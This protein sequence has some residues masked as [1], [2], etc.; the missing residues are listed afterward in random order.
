MS[1]PAII[2][3]QNQIGAIRQQLLGLTAQ[4]AAGQKPAP[5]VIGERDIVLFPANLSLPSN[6]DG[7]GTVF[8]WASSS[9]VVKIS[10]VDDSAS[11]AFSR[12]DGPDINSTLSGNVVTIT[13]LSADSGYVDI[14]ATKAGASVTRRLGVVKAK[15][16]L[17]GSS[18][19][20]LQL[21]YSIDGSTIWHSTPVLADQ[22]I[23]S[24]TDG[25]S[26]YGPSLK[27]VGPQGPAG[28]QG[29]QGTPG[30][31]G[32]DGLPSY[33][34]VA[35]ATAANGSAGF[36][37]TSGPYIGTYTDS[38]ATDSSDYTRYTWRQFV[39]SQ[40]PAGTDG[41]DGG[42]GPNGLTAYLH[43]KY[44]NDG[45]ATFTASSGETPGD[46]LG[47][48]TDNTLADSS[49]VGAYT[50]S[51]IVGPSGTPVTVEYSINGSTLWHPTFVTGDIYMRQNGGAAIKIVGEN[52]T[53]GTNGQYTD[54]RFQKNT[55]ATVAPS[56]TASADNPGASWLDAPATLSAGE[57]NWMI[58]ADWRDATRL[59][60]WSAPVR[61]TGDTGTS[62]IF[63]DSTAIAFLLPLTDM[64]VLPDGANVYLQDV[65]ANTSGWET[66]GG[67]GL[68]VSGGSLFVPGVKNGIYNNSFQSIPSKLVIIRVRATSTSGTIQFD[69]DAGSGWVNSVQ[70]Q[71]ITPVWSHFIRLFPTGTVSWRTQC[72][73]DHEIDYI[74]IGDG[75]Y[76][77]TT[78]VLDVSQN[79][80]QLTPQ[81]G[82]VRVDGPHGD[83]V[84]T[85]Y[86]YLSTDS[87]VSNI[88]SIS[89]RLKLETTNTNS[90]SVHGIN[91]AGGYG[92]IGFGEQTGDLGDESLQ[93]AIS[94]ALVF[95]VR[96]GTSYFFDGLWHHY[97]ITIDGT[98]NAVY[99]D[100]VRQS[101]YFGAGST[102]TD[103]TFSS[104]VNFGRYEGYP[105]N[106]KT[107]GAIADIRI[108]SRALSA[109]EVLGLYTQAP[110]PTVTDIANI[111]AKR[112]PGYLGSGS[113]LPVAQDTNDWALLTGANSV[114]PG[115]SAVD[116]RVVKWTGTTWAVSTDSGH[117]AAAVNDVLAWLALSES[118]QPPW[119]WTFI[120][121][122]VASK[123]FADEIAA[124]TL[125]VTGTIHANDG[126]FSGELK[127][128]HGNFGGL[129]SQTLTQING[130]KGFNSAA[131]QTAANVYNSIIA[132]VVNVGTPQWY[133]QACVGTY[134]PYTI[135]MIALGPQG[136]GNPSTNGSIGFY[137]LGGGSSWTW[138]HGAST[139]AYALTITEFFFPG[140]QLTNGIAPFADGAFTI[141]SPTRRFGAVYADNFLTGNPAHLA[142]IN[143]INGS[144]PNGYVRFSDGTQICWGRTARLTANVAYLGQY[145]SGATAI[146][147]PA[148]M[149]TV[150]S[151]SLGVI[152]T[153]GATCDAVTTG[154]IS[155]TGI[156]VY[157][158]SRQSLATGIVTFMVMGR[159]F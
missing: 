1:D 143:G 121:N 80:L 145:I 71:A 56:Y 12:T 48:Y 29:D 66:N 19:P 155:T 83:A 109:A 38:T 18:A 3:L 62:G 123:V 20:A 34:H 59:T 86:G 82:V 113:L 98:D 11:W 84:D 16:G 57:F 140:L 95:Y 144:D 126:D 124:A 30:P 138:I 10:G 129:E 94:P 78:K 32:P 118:N 157:A 37:Q 69:N 133:A 136:P 72:G 17:G 52:G 112:A 119:S 81:T 122:L 103:G 117:F 6:P 42:I 106:Y 67:G 111:V 76:A 127:A 77:P 158:Q 134:G 73:V 5:N 115:S 2:D 60:V 22:Y 41:I 47:Q 50:W 15:Q 25:G 141:G 87:A 137:G 46:W 58:Q 97:V 154:N 114:T 70:N 110:P 28:P 146:P 108:D 99:V 35:Y 53:N 130:Q 156:S 153:T 150:S 93:V 152:D 8:T 100:G 36:N 64:P 4:S 101:V 105:N 159:W 96:N 135:T 75:S 43:L 39:G 13:A 79:R 49:S 65:W 68:T 120:E 44:S 14:T 54:F 7:S 74:Y 9:F 61:L 33:F 102:T 149:T 104:I 131:G 55:S 40:G 27:F 91:V 90:I 63:P 148:V 45:G 31:A 24:S 21:Q 92:Y 151:I 147:W 139:L 132:N 107:I 26:T 85:T 116:C 125:T 89:M 142:F 23:R 128:A 88:R 51:K